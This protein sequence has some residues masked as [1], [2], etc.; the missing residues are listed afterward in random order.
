LTNSNFVSQVY[1][2]LFT[3][4][5]LIFKLTTTGAVDRGRKCRNLY[6]IHAKLEVCSW[7]FEYVA[8]HVT[9]ISSNCPSRGYP[10]ILFRNLLRNYKLAID[11]LNIDRTDFAV[12]NID[13]MYPFIW[14][15]SALLHL[16]SS[17]WF[18][19]LNSLYI[20]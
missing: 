17:G 15:D 20:T 1:I 2:K 5:E 13:I 19:I 12:L 10:I 4:T 6:P 18:L 7:L 16:I 3:F 11:V 8:L 14:Y 9:L